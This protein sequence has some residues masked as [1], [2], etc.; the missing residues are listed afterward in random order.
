M[1]SR[2]VTVHCVS[3]CLGCAHLDYGTFGSDMAQ[4]RVLCPLIVCGNQKGAGLPVGMSPAQEFFGLPPFAGQ[5][6]LLT[7]FTEDALRV[8]RQAEQEYGHLH[9]E[10]DDCS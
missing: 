4:G 3:E 1:I 9:F 5:F 7:P 8:I 10:E 2:M 6:D